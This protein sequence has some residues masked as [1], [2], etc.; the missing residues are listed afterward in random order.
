M[1]EILRVLM[2]AALAG[3]GAAD[4][5][6]PAVS[7]A[8]VTASLEDVWAVW[9]TQEGLESCIV[10][11]AE[12]DLKIGGLMRTHYDKHGRIGDGRTIENTI[13]SYEPL[14]MLSIKVSKA[15]EGFPF[16][17]AL[18]RMWTVIYFDPVAESRIRVRV[19]SLG[20]GPDEESRRLKAFFK[21]GN[22]ATLKAMARR[23]E[24]RK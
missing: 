13:L 3:P 8:V 21:A 12:I 22:D 11:Q 23:F 6:G 14:R 2:L 7:E 17:E 5:P 18:R 4:D 1:A 20:F 10:A 24:T 15:P 9:T 16:P 19:V